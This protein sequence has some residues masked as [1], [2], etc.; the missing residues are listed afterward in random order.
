MAD[1]PGSTQHGGRLFHRRHACPRLSAQTLSRGIRAPSLLGSLP[2]PV[3]AGSPSH[4]VPASEGGARVSHSILLRWRLPW[5]RCV[6]A[7]LELRAAATPTRLQPRRLWGLRAAAAPPRPP[8]RRP[9]PRREH[10]RRPPAAPPCARRR[11]VASCR[12]LPS[13]PPPPQELSK[14]SISGSASLESLTATAKQAEAEP[15]LLQHLPAVLKAAADKVRARRRAVGD[16]LVWVT[17]RDC[18]NPPA[19]LMVPVHAWAWPPCLRY[20]VFCAPT[21]RPIL[22]TPLTSAPTSRTRRPQDA[23]T[24]AAAEAAGAA[25][26]A[27]LNRNAVKLALPALFEAMADPK[28]QTK[29]VATNLLGHL[30]DASPEQISVR[31]G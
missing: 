9:A 1:V 3:G 10:L 31:V 15:Y 8:A 11:D 16:S 18:A 20:R 24:R 26:M 28:W 22:P 7:A 29:Q 2:Q 12:P 17:A 13:P 27:A 14:L 23:A 21:R 25:I 6:V 5:P 4:R 19:R 30:A